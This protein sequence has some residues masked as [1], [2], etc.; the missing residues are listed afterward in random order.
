MSTSDGLS[1]IPGTS[2]NGNW[3]RKISPGRIDRLAVFERVNVFP[4][5]PQLFRPFSSNSLR[6]S[7]SCFVLI[8]QEN[9]QAHRA[10]G[11]LRGNLGPEPMPFIDIA[12]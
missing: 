7:G 9:D 11:D 2:P 5:I 3:A 1:F 4:R 10:G 8:W 12:K 6:P